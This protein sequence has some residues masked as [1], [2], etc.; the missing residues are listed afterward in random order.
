MTPA[1][2]EPVTFRRVPQCRN[3][4]PPCTSTRKRDVYII[5]LTTQA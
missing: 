1:G 3:Q 4:L 5:M 2:T